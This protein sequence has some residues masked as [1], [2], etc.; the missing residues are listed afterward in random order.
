M[1]LIHVVS[2]IFTLLSTTTS[3]S[4]NLLQWVP[5]KSIKPLC[6]E[7]FPRKDIT[8]S[9]VCE[10][11]HTGVWCQ[12]ADNIITFCNA[13][14][15]YRSFCDNVTLGCLHPLQVLTVGGQR[16]LPLMHA[17]YEGQIGRCVLQ[18]AQQKRMHFLALGDSQTHAL[19]FELRRWL[20]QGVTMP[21]QVMARHATLKYPVNTSGLDIRAISPNTTRTYTNATEMTLLLREHLREIIMAPP[22]SAS[23]SNT[24]PAHRE[25]ELLVV[26]GHGVWD[27]AFSYGTVLADLKLLVPKIFRAV[28]D[29]LTNA[30]SEAE[31]AGVHMTIRLYTRNQYLSYGNNKKPFRLIP[32]LN[33]LTAGT[34]LA[35]KSR[36]QPNKA[37]SLHFLDVHALSLPRK[38]EMPFNDD[39]LHWAC[40]SKDKHFSSHCVFQLGDKQRPDEVGWAT[41]Q[42]MLLDLCGLHKLQDP[43]APAASALS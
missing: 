17:T 7:A 22:A 5:F 13:S 34:F 28:T 39:G 2:C 18:R 14:A 8:S 38:N 6:D 42:L 20:E 26:V 35:A 19:T 3:D 12:N 31:Q 1:L 30:L 10:K 43:A 25:L 4:N 21:N 37:L 36:L 32:A 40:L 23:S 29:C 41:V 27:L 33:E 15:N 24:D 9:G 16:V 11:Y